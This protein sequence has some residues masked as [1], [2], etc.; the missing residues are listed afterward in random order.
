MTASSS[1]KEK[2]LDSLL[3]TLQI[4]PEFASHNRI[5]EEDIIDRVEQWKHN[6]DRVLDEILDSVK[7]VLPDLS[8]QEQAD[9]IFATATF[10]GEGPWISCASKILSRGKINFIVQHPVLQPERFCPDILALFHCPGEP[11]LVQILTSNIKPLFQSN[12]HPSLNVSTGRKL[13]RPAGGPM[14]RQDYYEGQTWKNYPGAPIALSW[15]VRQVKVHT[16]H[17]GFFGA[18]DTSARV[19]LTK[20]SGISSS[21]L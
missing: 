3:P 2:L 9:V 4:P 15:C 14:A 13:S 6:A 20:A 11:L 8:L 18:T 5:T 21:L 10:D 7:Q 1:S 12:P 19:R 17:L 16:S